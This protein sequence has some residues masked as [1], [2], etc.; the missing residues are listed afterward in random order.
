MASKYDGLAKIIIQNV[1]GRENILNLSHCIT[2][3]RFRLKDESKVNTEILK[4]TDGVV[5][6][7]QSGGQ[8]QVVIGN[9]VPDVYAVICEKA[10]MTGETSANDDGTREKMGIGATLIDWISGIFQPTL[11]ILCAAGI[12]KGLLALWAFID[13]NAV[14][15]GAYQLWYSLGDGFFIFLPIVLGATAARKFGGNYFTGIAMGC[16]LC[17][18]AITGM[19]SAEAIGAVFSGTVF[20]MSYSATFFGIPIIMPSIIGYQS[21]VLPVI[22][23][24]YFTVKLENRLKNIL[25]D[26]IKTFI[27]PVITFAVMIPLTFLI[28]GPATSLMCSLMGVLFAAIFNIPAVGGLL[29]GCLLGAAWQVLVI[30][31]LHWGLIPLAMINLGSLGSDAVLSVVF[32]ASFAQTMTVLAIYIKSKNEKLKQIALPAFISG[33]FGVTEPCIYGI[34]LPKKKPFIISC[35]A[36]AIGGGIIGAAGCKTYQMGGLGIF[37]FPTFIDSVNQSL[38]SLIWAGIGV[39]VAMAVAFAVTYITYKDDEPKES[40]DIGTIVKN[41]EKVEEIAAPLNGDIIPLNE[42]P[43]EAF[44]SGALG[45]GLAILPAKGELFAPFDGEITTF[46]PTGHAIGIQS[47]DGAELLIHV[48]VDTVKLNGDGFTPKRRQGDRIKKGDLLLEFDI[49]EITKAGYSVLTPIIIT[50]SDEYADVILSDE[51]SAVYG[52]T[53]I[54]LLS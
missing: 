29:A 45:K 39:L 49:E 20:K 4:A 30:F 6:V 36:A 22:V 32:S 12:I 44:S 38:Y 25:P 31:G 1:G 53:L 41:T 50:N 10:H 34:T 17:Y 24:T 21:T 5:T 40:K 27:A 35:V 19:A 16:A 48:G 47:E 14:G 13:P 51:L 28:I 2:R 37:G 15:T 7:M 11:S 9:H 26:V 54:T 8:Y 52:Q 3:L 42:V 23:A 43:D 33:I 46:F 18:P